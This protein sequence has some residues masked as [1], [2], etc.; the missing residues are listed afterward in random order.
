MRDALWPYIGISRREG[1]VADI[2][3]IVERERTGND[4]HDAIWQFVLVSSRIGARLE[5]PPR[6]ADPVIIGQNRGP[7]LCC[8]GEC[9][10]PV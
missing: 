4:H 8:A 6:D 9:P 3:A 1:H 7:G 10:I 5:I 2:G